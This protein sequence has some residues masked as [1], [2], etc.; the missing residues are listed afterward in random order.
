MLKRTGPV[1]RWV[2]KEQGDYD[3]DR[4]DREFREQ[5]YSARG[6]EIVESQSQRDAQDGRQERDGR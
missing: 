6:R 1:E 4:F 5:L 2:H 3:V